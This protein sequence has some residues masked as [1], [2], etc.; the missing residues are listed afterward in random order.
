MRIL[1]QFALKIM[2]L[3][4]TRSAKVTTNLLLEDGCNILLEDGNYLLQE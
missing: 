2:T 4:L 1:L 3:P